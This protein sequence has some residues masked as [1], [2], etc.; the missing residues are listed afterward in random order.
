MSDTAIKK[1]LNEQDVEK[2]K[3]DLIIEPL[4]KDSALSNEQIEISMDNAT[5]EKQENE[6]QKKDIQSMNAK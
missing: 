1:H 5:G 3:N 4:E 6:E 2:V